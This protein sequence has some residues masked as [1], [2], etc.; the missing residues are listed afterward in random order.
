[1]KEAEETGY[2]ESINR[3]HLLSVIGGGATTALL[4]TGVGAAK[5]GHENGKSGNNGNHGNGNNGVGPCTC[6]GCPEGT[7][8]GKIEGAPEEGETYTFESDG[9]S[10]SVTIESV[11]EKD[12]GEVTC[13]SFSTDDV[14][15]QVCVKGG[16]DTKTYDD[17]PA[18]KEE[19][20]APTNP[21]GQQA[22]ISNVSFCGTG[23]D[24]LECYQI[25]LVSGDVIKD[26]EKG[27]PYGDRKFEDFSVC[28]DGS[29]LE[30]LESSNDGQSVDGCE[31][32]WVGLG[33][34]ESDNT[35]EVDVTL[36]SASSE[37]CTVTL[38]GYLLPEGETKFNPKTLEEQE[39]RDHETVELSEGDSTTLEISLNG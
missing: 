37:S 24:E 8:C 6:D 10:F 32:S 26:F 4:G 17:N 2:A 19:L 5:P 35:A 33:F 39:Y 18:E 3:R 9:D 13:F 21:G 30:G 11:T 7:F 22:A 16:P 31:L 34:D 12:G 38:A 14:V 27:G 1:M 20:C 28:E 15:E 25:D 23:D 36:E 29:N